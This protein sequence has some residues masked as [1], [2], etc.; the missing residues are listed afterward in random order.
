ML[1]ACFTLTLSNSVT[2]PNNIRRATP[3]RIM[4]A[5][6]IVDNLSPYSYYIACS[7]CVSNLMLDEQGVQL[8][9]MLIPSY[10]WCAAFPM[11]WLHRRRKEQLTATR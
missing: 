3:I 7:Y 2:L 10:A 8:R 5:E 9:S 11:E 1:L 4:A 6:R